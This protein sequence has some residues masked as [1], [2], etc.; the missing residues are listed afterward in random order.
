MRIDTKLFYDILL[1]RFKDVEKPIGSEQSVFVC[2]IENE[3]LPI[4]YN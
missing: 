3:P 4:N 1:V 2:F